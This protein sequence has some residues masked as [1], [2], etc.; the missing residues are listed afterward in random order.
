MTDHMREIIKEYVESS[1]EWQAYIRE[2][3]YKDGI[4]VLWSLLTNEKNSL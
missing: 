1:D 2:L 3:K 4:R